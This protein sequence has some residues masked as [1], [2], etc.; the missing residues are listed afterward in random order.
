MALL[1]LSQLFQG[2]PFGL[3]LHPGFGAPTDPSAAD[4]R[5]D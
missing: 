1:D 3:T 4:S 2:A 5:P